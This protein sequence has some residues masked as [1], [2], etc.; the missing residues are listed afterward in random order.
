VAQIIRAWSGLLVLWLQM[1]FW[2]WSCLPGF[3][4]H[5]V[6]WCSA[7]GDLIL[8]SVRR[9]VRLLDGRSIGCLVVVPFLDAPCAPGA[10][11]GCS[12]PGAILFSRLC[13][14]IT[15]AFRGF[16][17]VVRL[18][19]ARSSGAL[20]IF[21]D[22][23][24]C[25][26]LGPLILVRSGAPICL[27]LCRRASHTTLSLVFSLIVYFL[28]HCRFFVCLLFEV[29]L[30]LFLFFRTLVRLVKGRASRRGLDSCRGLLCSCFRWFFS[31]LSECNC[32]ESNC[33]LC[34]ST[35]MA[36]AQPPGLH[37]ATLSQVRY[38]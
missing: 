17:P 27:R 8:R 5:L 22:R 13:L 11:F 37:S 7:S 32:F 33:Q 3:S 20:T 15:C 4:D 6:V 18:F 34:Y 24:V 10:W 23:G 19:V 2:P 16:F 31:F 28:A 36:D 12:S 30:F 1:L 25:I 9:S 38:M 29:G 21:A 26:F 14:T 35:G